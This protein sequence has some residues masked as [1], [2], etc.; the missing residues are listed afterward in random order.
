MSAMKQ[1]LH[2]R[3]GQQ[4]TMTPQLQQAIRLLQLSTLDLQLE[5]Q[6]ALDSNL[7]L[8][9]AE[10][11]E[12]QSPSEDDPQ[13]AETESA[14]EDQPDPDSE[15]M[16]LEERDGL[17]EE[18]AMD[19]AWD[20][21]YDGGTA[22]SARD[23]DDERDPLENQTGGGESLQE[24][25]LWQAGL[26][27]FSPREAA[28]AGAIIDAVRDDGYLDCGLD[29]IQAALPAEWGVEP[30]EIESVLQRVQLLD[31]VGVAARDPRETLLV[32]LSQLPEDTPWLE[33]ARRLVADHLELLANRQYTQLRR[34]MK[35]EEDELSQVVALL[36]TLDPHPGARISNTQP[37][38]VVPDVF[39]RR[40]NGDW[41][42]EINSDAYPRLRVNGA[43][44]GLVRRADS[45]RDNSVMRQHLQEA[46]WLIKSL[47]SRN[48][49]LLK[50]A[51][52]IVERQRDF[53]DQGDE[54]MQ[55]L[56]L[57]EVAERIEMHES[58]VS[59][60][61]NQK[62]MRTPRGTFEFKYFFS[63]HVQTVD[64]GECSAT[65]IRARIR[66]LLAQEHP[67]KP[68]SDNQLAAELQ[69]Q[70]INVARRTV[71]KYREAM[72]IASSTERKRLS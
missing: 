24:Y 22:Y 60:I 64:G 41:L 4:L 48:E 62:Y 31:P 56:V 70:G 7:M 46:R 51:R 66:R 50:V 8:E 58:T 44:A 47:R 69:A 57:R 49:T 5:I 45:S 18:L 9:L 63:S 29:D 11:A 65:A 28:I 1:S 32:Q 3:L 36:Q 2:L 34:R 33:P 42:V 13:A 43:Y 72:G 55:P 37:E 39:V 30:A 21:I 40:H 38:Y 52:C 19:A 16:N 27:G 25:L 59:R 68:L 35:L 10:D 26:S 23:P 53:L 61:T 71:A 15:A 17:G 14:A 67:S 54:G 20:D 12:L 6:Q